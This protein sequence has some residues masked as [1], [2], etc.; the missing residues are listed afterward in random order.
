MYVDSTRKLTARVWACVC[1]V[2][3]CMCVH[4]NVSRERVLACIFMSC[5]M[6]EESRATASFDTQRL[7]KHASAGVL[8]N[9]A[10]GH[11][12]SAWTRLRVLPS[13]AGSNTRFWPTL[14]TTCA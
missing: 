11:K 12:V 5:L 13:Q 1:V 7:G 14:N 8:V 4:A 3:V 2:R 6:K 10:G 9:N